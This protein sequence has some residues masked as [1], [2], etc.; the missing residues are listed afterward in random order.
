M[1]P[2]MTLCPNRLFSSSWQE[3]IVSNPGVG[4]PFWRDIELQL[5]GFM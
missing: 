1:L 3:T 5:V 2:L 4:M